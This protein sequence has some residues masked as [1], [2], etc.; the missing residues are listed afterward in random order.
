ME[1]TP[2][3][4]AT[5]AAIGRNVASQ[6]ALRDRKAE[7]VAASLGIHR[8][9]LSSYEHGKTSIT[10]EMLHSIADELGCDVDRLIGVSTGAS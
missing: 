7:D 1:L 4:H 2:K 8:N 6:R 10:V 5:R 9:T 3:Q